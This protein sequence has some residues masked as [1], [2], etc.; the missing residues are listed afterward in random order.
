MK[1]QG[2][3]GKSTKEAITSIQASWKMTV[4]STKVVEMEAQDRKFGGDIWE[5]DTAELAGVRNEG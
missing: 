4:V 1:R 5:V 2:G 3:S